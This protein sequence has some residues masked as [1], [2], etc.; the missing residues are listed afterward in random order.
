MLQSVLTMLMV[1]LVTSGNGTANGRKLFRDVKRKM[2]QLIKQN[3]F[4][5]V[6]GLT[7]C[8]VTNLSIVQIKAFIRMKDLIKNQFL[9]FL[10]NGSQ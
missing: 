3:S 5:T 9:L 1:S 7:E 4:I 2:A 10:Y 6:T 8:I